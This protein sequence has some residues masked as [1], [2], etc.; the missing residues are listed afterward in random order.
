MV[1]RTDGRGLFVADLAPEGPRG[2]GPPIVC[3]HGLTRNRRDFEPALAAL[4][5]LMRRV[6]VVDTRGRGQSDPSREPLEYVPPVYAQDL[7]MALDALG[8]AE[9]DFVGTSMGGLITMVVAAFR[10]SLVRRVVLNDIGPVLGEQGIGR[11]LTYTREPPPP[12][13]SWAEAEALIRARAER[14]F[15]GRDAAFWQAFARRTCV[16]TPSGQ[17]LADYDPAI[18]APLL[19]GPSGAT[20]AD[21]WGLFDALAQR[22]VTVLRGVLSELLEPAIAAEMTRRGPDVTCV[23]V[24]GVGHAPLLDEPEAVAAIRERLA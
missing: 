14:E 11:I 13:A 5:P 3:L 2:D 17:V 23:E 19:A 4:H 24:A 10:P 1:P 8:V 16:E 21:L 6:L 12:M 15:P 18:V 7:L 20:P 9:A 22:P